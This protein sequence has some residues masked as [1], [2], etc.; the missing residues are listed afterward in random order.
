MI[1]QD[2]PK[3]QPEDEQHGDPNPGAVLGLQLGKSC[4]SSGRGRRKSGRSRC[5]RD[6]IGHRRLNKRKLNELKVR[7]PKPNSYPKDAG[8]LPGDAT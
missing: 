3:H 4:V 7:L 2:P 6:L 1:A 5:V 8:C